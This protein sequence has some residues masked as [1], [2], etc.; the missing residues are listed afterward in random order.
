M[1]AKK[2]KKK[3]SPPAPPPQKRGKGRPVGTGFHPTKEQRE[4]VQM[5]AS[6][7]IPE[8]EMLLLIKNKNGVPITAKT[9]R[10][11][12]R[13]ELDTGYTHLKTRLMAASVRDALGEQDVDATTGKVKIV[14][15]GNVTAQI[16]LQ[17]SLFG[18]REN[19][20]VIPPA[21]VA[22]EA[23]EATL[24]A[25]RRVAFTMALGARLAGKQGK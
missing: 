4:T 1:S 19:I 6:F 2:P 11:H 12:F 17:K 9:L 8:T 20:E 25:A 14:R 15:P 10:K 16:W 23:D 18:A 7:R 24:D 13:E 3:T 5:M 21:P 22:D